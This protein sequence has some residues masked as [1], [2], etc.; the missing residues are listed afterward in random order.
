MRPASRHLDN[1]PL[2]ETCLTADDDRPT[3]LSTDVARQDAEWWF[4]ELRLPVYRYVICTGMAPADAE[5]VVQETFLRLYQNLQK[6]GIRSNLRGWI[7]QVA[8][9]AARDRRK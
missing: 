8:R 4:G 7:F 3:T 6:G 1:G 9:N 5:E 2:M